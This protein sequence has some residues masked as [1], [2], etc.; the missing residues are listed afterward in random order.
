MSV[1]FQPKFLAVHTLFPSVKQ[2][3]F[4]IWQKSY[5]H[6][7]KRH[8][9]KKSPTPGMK[10]NEFFS[11]YEF[12]ILLFGHRS[13]LNL[14]FINFGISTVNVCLYNVSIS[15]IKYLDFPHD[16]GIFSIQF[17]GNI[18]NFYKKYTEQKPRTTAYS[19][20]SDISVLYSTF[21]WVFEYMRHWHSEKRTATLTLMS[22][23]KNIKKLYFFSVELWAYLNRRLQ[24]ISK[25]SCFGS[26]EKSF[27][28]ITN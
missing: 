8:Q 20:T 7:K 16:R 19:L 22:W 11:F 21:D 27:N 14:E 28:F 25:N 5:Q 9:Q 23:D 17:K 15:Q 26:M 4:L 2:Y 18:C 12:R 6:K 10:L 24:F 1:T 13:Y 3:L